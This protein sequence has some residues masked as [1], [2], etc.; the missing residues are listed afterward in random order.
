MTDRRANASDVLCS[1][2]SS[3]IRSMYYHYEI[4]TGLEGFPATALQPLSRGPRLVPGIV[5]DP[6]RVSTVTPADCTA[7]GIHGDTVAGGSQAHLSR[8]GYR[9]RTI[10]STYP[11]SNYFS[12]SGCG[13]WRGSFRGGWR[14]RAGV[15][16]R[17]PGVRCRGHRPRRRAGPG[18]ARRSSPSHRPS[19]LPGTGR[20]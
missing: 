11:A 4:K 14:G 17:A 1:V 3:P 16:P 13:Q 15:V 12:I 8:T 2:S 6:F 7:A 19:R 18:G 10:Y 5:R 20:G 9:L